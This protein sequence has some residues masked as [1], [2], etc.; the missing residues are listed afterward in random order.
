MGRGWGIVWFAEPAWAGCMYLEFAEL[1]EVGVDLSS[2]R[3]NLRG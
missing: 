2:L 1:T 3:R